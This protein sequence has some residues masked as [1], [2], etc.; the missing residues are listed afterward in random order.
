[1]LAQLLQGDL[2]APAKDALRK[3]ALHGHRRLGSRMW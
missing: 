3:M 2:P 1:V